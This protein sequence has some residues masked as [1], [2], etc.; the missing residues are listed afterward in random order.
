MMIGGEL[1]GLGS[2]RFHHLVSARRIVADTGSGSGRPTS[3]QTAQA[4]CLLS[5]TFAYPRTI[6]TALPLSPTPRYVCYAAQ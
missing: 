3:V 2:Q 5:A 1:G 4:A 6:V